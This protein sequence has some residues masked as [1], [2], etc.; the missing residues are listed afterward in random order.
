VHAR[1]PILATLF[2]GFDGNLL[3]F[4]L[5]LRPALGIE[6]HNGAI[7][8]DR[9]N[10]GRTNLDCLLHNEIH[11]FPFWDCLSENNPATQRRRFC[12]VQF[13]QSNLAV[14]D[15]RNFCSEFAACSVEEDQLVSSLHAQ[16]VARVVSFGT[17]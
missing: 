1:Q 4:V 6:V 17:A 2:G 13:L 9:R 12:F 7:G 8:N 3:P 10:L 11:V 5:F 14:A 15:I 16:D